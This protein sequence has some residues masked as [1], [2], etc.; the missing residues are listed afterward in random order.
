VS[1]LVESQLLVVEIVTG[2]GGSREFA[3]ATTVLAT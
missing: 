3:S 1:Q 2:T